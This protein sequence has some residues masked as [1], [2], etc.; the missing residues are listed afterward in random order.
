MPPGAPS[1]LH[2]AFRRGACAFDGGTTT[3]AATDDRPPAAQLCPHDFA[4]SH[5]RFRC[6][7]CALCQRIPMALSR[8]ICAAVSFPSRHDVLRRRQN[9]APDGLAQPSSCWQCSRRTTRP[10][11]PADCPD[12]GYAWPT[13]PAPAPPDIAQAAFPHPGSIPLRRSD[14]TRPE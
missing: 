5:I 13:V 7:S 9:S 8:R 11:Y 2:S 14:G 4:H 3:A 1:G 12:T 10:P 6:S